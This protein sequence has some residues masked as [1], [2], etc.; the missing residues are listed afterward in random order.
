MIM[1]CL[2]IFIVFTSLS[3]YL[4]NFILLLIFIRSIIFDSS[5]LSDIA[6]QPLDPIHPDDEPQLERA[7]SSAERDAPMTIVNAFVCK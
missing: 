4:T 5:N 1:P 2:S 6:L 3:H 7:E